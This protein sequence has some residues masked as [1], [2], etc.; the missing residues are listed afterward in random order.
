MFGS[1]F[2]ETE[3]VAFLQKVPARIVVVLDEC[4]LEFVEKMLKISSEELFSTFENV[5]GLRSFSKFYG[6]P[7][8]RL[9]YIVSSADVITL[10]KANT[11]WNNIPNCVLEVA[12]DAEPKIDSVVLYN[13]ELKRLKTKIQKLGLAVSQSFIYIL[14]IEL[15]KQCT[16]ARICEELKEQ[17]IIIT[18]SQALPNTMCYQVG[19]REI[20]DKFLR[21]LIRLTS[22]AF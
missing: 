22:G 15:P 5:I 7:D 10:T 13:K 6:L 11:P 19:T 12:I 1:I 18:N 3:F 2:N 21:L 8:I 16:F 9:G 20:N 14:V 17:K 4:Y